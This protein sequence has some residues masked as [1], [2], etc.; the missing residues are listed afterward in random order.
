M[1]EIMEWGGGRT[2]TEELRAMGRKNQAVLIELKKKERALVKTGAVKQVK[3]YIDTVD[4]VRY[5]YADFPPEKW[6]FLYSPDAEL[7]TE[8]IR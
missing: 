7:T 2:A 4:G 3:V 6:S 1:L 8:L 5:S